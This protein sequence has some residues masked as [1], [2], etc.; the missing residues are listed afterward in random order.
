MAWRIRIWPL[1]QGSAQRL[2][3]KRSP[4]LRPPEKAHQNDTAPL[5]EQDTLGNLPYPGFRNGQHSDLCRPGKWEGKIM[6]QFNIL[7][8]CI[9]VAAL[10][11]AAS[12]AH[13]LKYP[14]KDQPVSSSGGSSGGTPVPEPSSLALFGAGAAAFMLTKRRRKKAN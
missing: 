7:H 13:A 2:T 5:N 6:R 12:P 10:A 9:V 4:R 11:I 14:P 1:D 8:A 3:R